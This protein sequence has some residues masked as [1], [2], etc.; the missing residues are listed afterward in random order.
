MGRLFGTD[1]IRGIANTELT[2]ETAMQLGR[3]LA[4]VLNK[5]RHKRADTVVLGMDTRQSSQM[6]ACAISAGLCSAG[7]DVINLGVVP[8][9]AVAYLIGKYKAHAGIMISASHNPS[10]F[11]GIKIFGE[12]GVKLPDALEERVE[13]LILDMP[14]KLVSVASDKIGTVTHRADAIKDYMAH[15]RSTVMYAFDGVEIA[16][17]CANGSAS[18]M[19]EELFTSLGAKCHML[20]CEPDGFNIN[21]N[22][23]STK[24]ETLRE[25]VASNGLFMGIAFDGDADRCLCVNEK[26]DVVDGDLIMAI[27]AKDMKERG[28][29]T[30]NAIVGTIVSNFGLS[31]FCEDNEIKFVRTKVGDRYVLE[32][33]MLED[34]YFGGEQT[35]HV[36]FRDF[37][38]TGDGQLTSLQLL[39]ILC[40]KGI[41]LS[42]ASKVMKQYPQ[43]TK[44]IK[45]NHEQRLEFYTSD[46]VQ[47]IIEEAKE[48]LGKTGRVVVRPSGTEPLIRVM[49]EGDDMELVESIVD[50]MS[51]DIAEALSGVADQI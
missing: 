37:A 36:V 16:I 6:L 15:L 47:D 13:Y 19:A 39:S 30:G 4:A 51:R 27:I 17:D 28:R 46:K 42:E 40:R 31:K 29:L 38:T 41:T 12:A 8:T 11:N 35:G 23:G 49:A 14:E 34:Y 1:G 50:S 45:A 22:C 25:Y 32:K 5:G 48:A 9:P 3:A 21:E 18:V 7:M 24:L 44:N 43:V 20:S 2:C 33:M 10:E 26:G